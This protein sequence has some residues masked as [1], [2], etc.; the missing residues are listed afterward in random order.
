[1]ARRSTMAG[2]LALGMVAGSGSLQAQVTEVARSPIAEVAQLTFGHRCDDRFVIR[3]D[4]T[5]P[6]ELEYAVVKQGQHYKLSLGAREQIELESKSKE[7]MELWMDGKLVATADKE[8][9]SCKGMPGNAS[10]AIAPLEVPDTD[11]NDRPAYRYGPGGP[12]GPYDPWVGGYYYGGIG[13]R[14]FYSAYIGVPI[15]IGRGGRGGPR[16]R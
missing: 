13:M 16:G 7:A 14:P 3:N 1:M 12:W 6:V 10:V 11:R 2:A 4:G 9:R 15:V 8:K 5:K